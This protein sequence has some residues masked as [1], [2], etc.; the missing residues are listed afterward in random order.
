MAIP[1]SV[2]FPYGSS[3]ETFPDNGILSMAYDKRVTQND[4]LQVTG[5]LLHKGV[6]YY[7]EEALDGSGIYTWNQDFIDMLQKSIS[8]N[9]IAN[10]TKEQRRL[11][12]K[13]I[14][15]LTDGITGNETEDVIALDTYI[16]G[17][18]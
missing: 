1:N 4:I 17:L 8:E 10:F 15:L 16:G 14:L 18:Q 3:P 7:R 9:K 13:Y 6:A 5:K 2:L 11:F 12:D